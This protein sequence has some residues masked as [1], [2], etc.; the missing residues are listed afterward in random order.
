VKLFLAVALSSLLCGQKL[1]FV[2]NDGLWV[3]QIPDGAARAVV[4]SGKPHAP[5]FSADGSWI[6]FLDGDQ[7]GIVASTGGEIQRPLGAESV[8]EFRWCG[9]GSALAFA[10]EDSVYVASDEGGWKPSRIFVGEPESI[11]FSPDGTHIAISS[12]ESDRDGIP[13]MGRIEIVAADAS[14]PAMRLCS[15]A[16]FEQLILTAWS[17]GAIVFWKGPFSGSQA[18]DGFEIY[19]IPAT[20]GEVRKL[21]GPTLLY[22]ELHAVSPDGSKIALTNGEGRRTWTEKQIAVADLATG[23]LTVLTDSKTAALSPAW[24]PDGSLI[25]YVAAADGGDLW[26]DSGAKQALTRRRIWIMNADGSHQHQ[27]TSDADFR[28]EQ[29]VWSGD[30]KSLIFFRFDHDD[31]ASAWS[32]DL[33]GSEPTLLV[34]SITLDEQD[35][36]FG[37][38]GY[39]DWSDRIALFLK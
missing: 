9:V 34:N 16:E 31:R 2:Q 22:D 18:S 27:I 26:G 37:D 10:T 39:V 5:K 3:K 24:S 38:Y 32:I 11:R 4:E 20:G 15:G 7:L 1:A 21:S 23:K 17:S 25:A 35:V 28:D 19:A 12:G 8:R 6:A 30:G 36:W 29:P 14:A 33:A 13:G